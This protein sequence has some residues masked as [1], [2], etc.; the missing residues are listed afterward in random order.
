MDSQPSTSRHRHVPLTEEQLKFYAENSNNEEFWKEMCSDSEDDDQVGEKDGENDEISAK[1]YEELNT[2]YEETV[3]DALHSYMFSMLLI[4]GGCV[5]TE[6]FHLPFER[7]VKIDR[8]L[9][10]PEHPTLPISFEDI[11][12]TPVRKTYYISGKIIASR[13]ISTKL[14]LVLKFERCKSK[15]SWDSCEPYNDLQIK[16]ICEMTFSKFKPWSPFVSSLKP[17]MD[18][19]L[20]KGTYVCQNGTFDG[21]ALSVFPLSGWFWK[22]YAKV[23]ET[24]ESPK[25]VMCTYVEGQITNM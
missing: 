11:H 3:D 15:D 16:N 23:F 17:A 18:C 9:N 1:K 10:C 19:P 6:G 8:F 12:F 24:D 14:K 21:D 4:V 7:T 22:V 20:E 2:S 5:C 25:L 13:K